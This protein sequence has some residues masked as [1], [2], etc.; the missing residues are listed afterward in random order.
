MVISFVIAIENRLLGG[1]FHLPEV[2]KN[3]PRKGEKYEKK[4]PNCISST[5]VDDTFFFARIM[6]QKAKN[7][8]ASEGSRL[9][10]TDPVVN[11]SF[12]DLGMAGLRFAPTNEYDIPACYSQVSEA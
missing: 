1:C 6:G 2:C 10:V 5:D 11:R 7:L 4:V 8:P 9:V 12:N 3:Y